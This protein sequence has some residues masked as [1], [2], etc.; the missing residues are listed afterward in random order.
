ME[1]LFFFFFF[2]A[3]SICMYSWQHVYIFYILPWAAMAVWSDW[4]TFLT[5]AGEASICSTSYTTGSS[6]HGCYRSILSLFF[7][8]F[9]LLDYRPWCGFSTQ[10]SFNPHKRISG[11]CCQCAFSNLAGLIVVSDIALATCPLSTLWPISGKQLV[12]IV[13]WLEPEVLRKLS[14]KGAPERWAWQIRFQC[15]II[16]RAGTLKP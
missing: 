1:C 3:L 16:N 11:H 10:Q 14:G 12:Y 9:L 6:Q 4:G 7:H 2:F 13:F 8:S 15:Y 5:S